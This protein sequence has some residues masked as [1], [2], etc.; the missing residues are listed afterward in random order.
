MGCD[1]IA[2]EGVW[3]ESGGVEDQSSRELAME[4]SRASPSSDDKLD[5]KI[6]AI[7]TQR[8]PKVSNPADE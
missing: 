2:M 7:N 5:M 1:W 6:S 3:V 8:C 4:S